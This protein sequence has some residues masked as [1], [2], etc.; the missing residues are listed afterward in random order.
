M[1]FCVLLYNQITTTSFCFTQART[2]KRKT[3]VNSN[4]KRKTRVRDACFFYK[5]ISFGVISLYL[6][7]AVV[8]RKIHACFKNILLHKVCILCV[9]ITFGCD[10]GKGRPEVLYRANTLSHTNCT[11]R[12]FYYIYTLPFFIHI[13]CTIY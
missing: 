12:A 1:R 13:K 2:S 11:L 5:Y 8:S 9:C 7:R 3:R 10:D 6:M 4:N